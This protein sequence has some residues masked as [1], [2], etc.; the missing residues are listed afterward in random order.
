MLIRFSLY[1]FLKNQRYYEPFLILAFLEKGLSF[2]V[3]GVLISFREI[4]VNLFEVLS[5]AA[6]DL[7][8]R[9]RS[10]VLSF[11]SYIVSFLIFAASS[12]LWTLFAAM[13]FFALGEAFRTGTH[14]AMIFDWLEEQGRGN[15]K[16]RIY[17]VTSS[18][19]QIGS[20]VSVLIAALIVP[21][22]GRYSRVFL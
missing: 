17:G 2:F 1:G 11:S 14:K 19:S 18:W 9:R 22:E 3:I 5:G 13:L 8:G 4:C 20:A 6:V 15:E 21:L 12:E 7:Y 16:A 10:M